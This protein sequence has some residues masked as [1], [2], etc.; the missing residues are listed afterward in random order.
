M[1]E[2]RLRRSADV[3]RVIT[4]GTRAHG[5]TAV[6]H[7]R[8]RGDGW[9]PRVTVVAGR[10]VGG[11]VQ[12]NRAKRR[13]REALRATRLPEGLDVVVVARAEA[14]AAPWPVL[15]A[16]LDRLLARCAGSGVESAR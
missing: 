5:R 6:V 11:A 7:A 10:K 4:A 9:A 2:Q 14:V 12:R 15:V 16:E 13:L 3:R 1:A 8:R